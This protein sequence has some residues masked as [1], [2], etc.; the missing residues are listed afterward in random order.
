MNLLRAAACHG[1]VAVAAE[2]LSIDLMLPAG[3][4]APLSAAIVIWINSADVVSA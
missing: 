3:S 2:A 4:L 1:P